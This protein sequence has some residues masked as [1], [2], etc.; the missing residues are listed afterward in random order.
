M[1]PREV[2]SAA[3]VTGLGTELLGADPAA[4]TGCVQTLATWLDRDGGRVALRICEAT[5][6]SEA[7][8]FMLNLARARAEAIVTTG[9]ILREEA[10]VTHAPKGPAAVP[11]ALADW[12]RSVLGLREPPLLLVLSSG[13]GL[14]PDHPAFAAPVRPVLFVPEAIAGALASQF[15]G[16]AAVE[17]AKQT[18]AREAVEWLRARGAERITV[19]AGPSASAP[20]YERPCSIDELWRSTYLERELPQEIIGPTLLPDSELDALLPDHT[21]GATVREPSGPWRFERL[22]ATA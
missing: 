11:E 10:D 15:E 20:L 1:R 6:R 9:S 12:R 22:S 2:Q 14:S 3:D 19:E 17:G 21:A 13:R 5:P 16:R 18:G 8:F 7:D 4:A